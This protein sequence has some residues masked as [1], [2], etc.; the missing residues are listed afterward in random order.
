MVILYKLVILYEHLELN[1]KPHHWFGARLYRKKI[2]YIVWEKIKIETWK[3][4]NKLCQRLH[5]L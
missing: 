3:K 4:K 2:D 1:K 5:A